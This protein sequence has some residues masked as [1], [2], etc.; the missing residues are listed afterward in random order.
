MS[1][2]LEVYG[3]LLTEKQQRMI[4]DYYNNDLSLSEIGESED[5]T[6]QAARDNIKNGEAKLLMYEE[7][8]GF[9]HKRIELDKIVEEISLKLEDIVVTKENKKNIN[10]IQKLLKMIGGK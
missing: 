2:L 5:I 6:R 4:Y 7:K 10:D 1:M 9:L 8:L 3:N